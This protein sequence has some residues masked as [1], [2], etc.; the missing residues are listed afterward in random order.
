MEDIGMGEDGDIN[1]DDY[2]RKYLANRETLYLESYQ[3]ET[4]FYT[5]IAPLVQGIKIPKVYYNFEDCFNNKFGFVLQDAQ[6][7]CD[8]LPPSPLSLL[9][10]ITI[11]T[12]R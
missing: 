1:E 7:S 5:Q 2:W 3:N 10:I 6:F 11:I 8:P 4:R 9:I 12:R